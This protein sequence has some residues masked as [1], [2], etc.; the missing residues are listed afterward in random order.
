MILCL[1]TATKTCS[2]ALFRGKEL[3]AELSESGDRFVHSERLHVLIGQLLE[4]AGIQTSD[5]AGILVGRG[6]GSYTGLRIGVSAA[7]GLAYA[8]G[9]A[10]YSAPT[11][12]AFD[13]EGLE[14]DRAIAVLDARRNEVYAQRWER[15]LGS[16]QPVGEVEAEIVSAQSWEDWGNPENPPV[17]LGDATAKIPE[18]L[19]E[20]AGGFKLSEPKDPQAAFLYRR[21]DLEKAVREDVAYFEPFYLKDFVAEKS[22]KKFF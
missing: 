1:E 12:G 21:F 9:I 8:R 10:L 5:L 7:K 18:L 22:K 16:W 20:S 14:Q 11:L 4:G 15:T 19:G 13:L 2:V 6:P 17:I 3:V